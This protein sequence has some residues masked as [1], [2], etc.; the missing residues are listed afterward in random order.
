MKIIRLLLLSLCLAT[1]GLAWGQQAQ[2]ASPGAANP[3]EAIAL[4]AHADTFRAIIEQKHCGGFD[5]NAFA[6]VNHRLEDARAQLIARFGEKLFSA[7]KSPTDLP[8]QVG[9]TPFI[10]D[11]YNMHVTD[12]EQY[13]KTRVGP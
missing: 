5:R 13:L 1:I 8:P 9:C 12:I 7:Y 3:Y 10:L 6:A 11:S 2:A 4:Y